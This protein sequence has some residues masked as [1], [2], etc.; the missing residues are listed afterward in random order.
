MLSP[1]RY[2]LQAWK[3]CKDSLR[4]EAKIMGKMFKING[5]FGKSYIFLDNNWHSFKTSGWIISLYKP[6]LCAKSYI[7]VMYQ[8]K[9]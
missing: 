3:M 9:K 8:R 6:T 1:G 5:I 4:L 2:L 7:E